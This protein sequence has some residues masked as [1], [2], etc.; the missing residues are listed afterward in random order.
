[1]EK[2]LQNVINYKKNNNKKKWIYDYKIYLRFPSSVLH[3][4]SPLFH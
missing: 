4:C 2:H 1:M 3:C